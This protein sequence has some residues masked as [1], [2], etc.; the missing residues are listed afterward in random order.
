M[1]PGELLAPPSKKGT[2]GL[3]KHQ[4]PGAGDSA[5]A[6]THVPP[7]S[8]VDQRLI[9]T[10]VTD[11]GDCELPDWRTSKIDRQSWLAGFVAGEAGRPAYGCLADH[12][13]YPWHSGWVEGDA[14]RQGREYSFRTLN[15]A[16]LDKYKTAR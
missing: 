7:G 4:S 2:P 14:K 9:L 3:R 11:T 10:I 6:A 16:D 1:P 12:D 13:T 15:P 8:V 5:S